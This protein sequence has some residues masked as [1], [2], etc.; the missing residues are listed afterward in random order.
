MTIQTFLIILK[1]K[2]ILKLLETKFDLTT[3][4]RKTV[5]FIHNIY[6][7]WKVSLSSPLLDKQ[8]IQSDY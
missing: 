5:F 1:D 7:G 6:R 3:I 8:S 4:R 2:V